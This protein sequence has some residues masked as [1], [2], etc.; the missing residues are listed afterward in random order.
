MASATALG[1]S[2][3][4]QGHQY[5]RLSRL[6][7]LQIEAEHPQSCFHSDSD[8]AGDNIEDAMC[9]DVVSV[10]LTDLPTGLQTLK[11]RETCASAAACKRCTDMLCNS[12]TVFRSECRSSN[13]R[14]NDLN[15][16]RNLTLRPLT[17]QDSQHL[18]MACCKLPCADAGEDSGVREVGS[19]FGI[20]GAI[21]SATLGSPP[22]GPGGASLTIHVPRRGSASSPCRKGT[23]DSIPCLN[24][25]RSTPCCCVTNLSACCVSSGAALPCS[26][27]GAL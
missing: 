24:L 27:D 6:R 18:L 2:A 15:P 13:R 11:V 7:E 20:G 14:A 26:A 5:T 23:P 22:G 25:M 10:D 1:P 9:D 19:V 12:C 21:S 4:T 17:L 8:G 16:N 3:P